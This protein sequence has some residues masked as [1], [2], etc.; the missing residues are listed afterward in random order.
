MQAFPCSVHLYTNLGKEE[1]HTRSI[2]DVLYAFLQ[3]DFKEKMA[4]CNI[5]H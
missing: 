2:T 4:F 3:F 1:K 5:C